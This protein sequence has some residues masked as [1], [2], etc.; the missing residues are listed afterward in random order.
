VGA[1]TRARIGEQVQAD[2][3]KWGEVVRKANIR[4][5]G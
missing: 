4:L 3:I 1:W 5:E 2:L